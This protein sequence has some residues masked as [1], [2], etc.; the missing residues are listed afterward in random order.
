MTLIN[1]TPEELRVRHERRQTELAER[2]Q[3]WE[4]RRRRFV[5][6]LAIAGALV[7]FLSTWGASAG[8]GRMEWMMWP[9]TV[10]GG[11][12][13]AA[14][15]AYQSLGLLSGMAVY[16]IGCFGIWLIGFV[17]GWWKLAPIGDMT[18]AG[19]IMLMICAWL[20]WLVA[21]SVFGLLSSTFDDDNAQV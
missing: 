4:Q 20:A 5:R 6:K 18:G 19:P 17:I 15:I 16:G 13:L 1:P 14:V 8:G 9:L 3:R 7:F 2:A 11:A 10:M 12:G 21:G